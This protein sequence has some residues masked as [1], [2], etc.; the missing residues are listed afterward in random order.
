MGRPRSFDDDTVV[1]RA[2][3]AFWT[4]GYANTS[5]AQL[6]EAT[7]VGK[8]SLYNAFG[9]KRELFD[10]ALIRYDQAGAAIAR[11][12]LSQPG[13]TRE[14]IRELMRFLVDSDLSQPIRR[15]CMAVNIATEFAG[16]DQEITRILR[17]MQDHTIDALACRI[18]QGVREGDVRADTDPQAT[19][20]FLLNT[21]AGLRV[22]A[23]VYNAPTLYGII[24]T[25]LQ[26]L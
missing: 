26:I 10:R 25:A 17:A 2:M 22:T 5:P 15:G 4:H 23:K 9:S 8:G 19:A 18:E 3:E 6:A 11:D 14:R 20:E 7:G 21:I 16:N 1:E 12:V 24:D 13:S